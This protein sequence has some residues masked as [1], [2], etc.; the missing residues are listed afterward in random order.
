MVSP[1][2]KCHL[3]TWRVAQ[4]LVRHTV[5][6]LGKSLELCSQN[7]HL[8]TTETGALSL[9]AMAEAAEEALG[10]L[11]AAF[12]HRASV[13]QAAVLD[14]IANQQLTREAAIECATLPFGKQVKAFFDRVMG[15]LQK[16]STQPD[17]FK[18]LAGTQAEVQ[19]AGAAIV[20]LIEDHLLAV[21][22]A[23]EGG[24]STKG[25]LPPCG[26][27]IGIDPAKYIPK[28][29]VVARGICAILFICI[30]TFTKLCVGASALVLCLGTKLLHRSPTGREVMAQARATH[31]SILLVRGLH[32]NQMLA[33]F[34][35][36]LAV[37]QLA[38]VKK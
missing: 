38:A 15:N 37:L 32:H 5:A 30:N 35:Q 14:V 7:K 21:A 34:D 25:L 9:G 31:R 13:F 3:Q 28:A 16:I 2:P 20:R 8:L 27:P 17:P 6:A 33:A 11:P 10:E 4:E 22:Q 36:V 26:I 29:L 24:R 19:T 23:L 18:V 12:I 1:V